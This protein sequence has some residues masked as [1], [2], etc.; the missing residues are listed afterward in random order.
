VSRQDD[1]W[2]IQSIYFEYLYS[3]VFKVRDLGSRDSYLTVCAHLHRV[4]FWDGVA[5]DDNR[6]IEGEELRDEFVAQAPVIEVDDYA[7]LYSIGKAT[8]LEVLIAL[9]RRA[10]FQVEIGIETWM[11]KFL[12]NLGLIKFNDPSFRL[13]HRAKVERIIRTF[14]QRQYDRNGQG[15]LFPLRYSR[16]DQRQVELWYQ[17]AA[18]MRENRMY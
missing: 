15:G 10:N 6:R 14:N 13:A 8:V 5:N 2:D 9:A 12:E 11:Q 18:Y 1:G 17:M 4:E 16:R 7:K 3:Q